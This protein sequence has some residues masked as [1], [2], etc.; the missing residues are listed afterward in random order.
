MVTLGWEH[1]LDMETG[2]PGSKSFLV[3]VTV[4]CRHS[5]DVYR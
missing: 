5:Q 3:T 4:T 1:G 2:D